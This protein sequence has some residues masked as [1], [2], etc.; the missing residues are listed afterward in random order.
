MRKN[1]TLRVLATAVLASVAV[2]WAQPAG[3]RTTADAPLKGTVTTADGKPMEGVAVSLRAEGRN[4]RTTVYTDGAGKYSFPP[5]E[6]LRYEMLVQAVGYEA[7]RATVSVG[8]GPAVEQRFALASAKDF[9]RQLTAVEWMASLPEDTPQD[10]RVKRLLTVNCNNCHNMATTV[11]NRFDAHGWNVIVTL[12]EKMGH[13]GAFNPQSEPDPYIRGYKKELV[14]YLTRVRGPDSKLTYR[15]LPRV[16][17][18]ATQVVVTEYDVSPGHLPGYF[19]TENGSDWSLGTPSH[20]ESRAVHDHV[21]DLQGNVWFTDNATPKRSIGKLDPRTGT[22][23][24]YLHVSRKNEPVGVH[25]INVD[26][27]GYLW[28]NNGPDGTLDRFDP[29]TET[30]RHF[31]TP[32]SSPRGLGGL[33]GVDSKGNI[34]G[35]YGA[36]RIREFDKEMSISYNRSDPAQPGGAAKLNPKTG[37]YTFYKAVSPA[38]SVYSIGIDA[39]DNAWFTQVN[40]DRLGYVDGRTGQVGEIDLS[41]RHTDD[42]L[43]TALDAKLAATFEPTFGLAGVGPPWLKGPRRQVQSWWTAVKFADPKTREQ[44][45]AQW[46]TLSKSNALAKVDVRTK[47]V[48]EYP[49]PYPNSFPYSVTVDKNYMVWLSATNTDRLFKFNPFTERWTVYPL[50]TLGTDSRMIDVDNTTDPPTVWLSYWGTSQLA[51]VQFRT[52]A[53]SQSTR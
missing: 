46:F 6:A 16:A 24:D 13:S 38:M 40:V 39:H 15:P 27:E 4:I 44:M 30:F 36:G 26:Q 53:A 18:D 7:G 41:R 2:V 29:R 32:A 43:H 19:V 12:M 20:Y 37:E 47:K 35:R 52:S 9:S 49:L 23:T 50:P 17:G 1:N 33:I 3:V 5:L 14:D 22:V 31:P 10:K 51:R 42:V 11:Q 28:F 34:W 21:V 25:D 8:T 48:T 45:N